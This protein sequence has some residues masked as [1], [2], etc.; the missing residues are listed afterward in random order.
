MTLIEY[1]V[2]LLAGAAR[3][4]QSN[5]I[6]L[7]LGVAGLILATELILFFAPGVSIS[8]L[9]IALTCMKFGFVPSLAIV[10]PPIIIAHYILLRNPTI[11][12]GDT[13]AMVVMVLFGAYAGPW[14]IASVGWGIFG[15]LFGIVKWGTLFVL[16]FMYGGNKSKRIQNLF[17][18]PVFNFFIFWK[19]RLLFGFL[20]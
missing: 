8:T 1:S 7:M 10:I 13:V 5:D 18:E 15:V 12:I 6:L 17:L 20:I 14:L 19:L 4:F 16:S 2:P 11:A 3:Q 9:L